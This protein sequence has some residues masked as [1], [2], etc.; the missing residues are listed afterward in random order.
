MAGDV[1]ELP[2]LRQE[3]DLVAGPSNFDGSPTWSLYDPANQRY[4]RIGQIE[5]EILMAWTQGT[6]AAVVEKIQQLDQ[7]SVTEEDVTELY[8]FLFSHNLLQMQG[9]EA[10]QHLLKQA[11][12][13]KQHW[14]SW[15]VHHYLFFKLPLLRPDRLL[16]QTYPYI[17]CLYQPVILYLLMAVLVINLYVLIDR[18]ELFSQTFLHFFSLEGMVFYG[19]ALSLAKI[20]HELGHAYTAHRYGCRVATMGVAFLVMFPVL[21]TDT[22]D[23]W[24]LTSRRQRLGIAIAGIAVELAL[25]IICTSLWHFLPDGA[26]RSAVFLMASTTWIMTLL[27]NL[28]PFMRFDGYYLLSDFLGVENLQ[29]RAFNLAKWQLRRALFAMQETLPEQLPTRLHR[30]LVAYAWG[31]WVYRFLLFLGIA[32]LVYHFFFKA[33]GVILMMIEII[34]FIALP[35]IKEIKH[36]LANREAISWNKNS[37]LTAIASVLLLLICFIPWQSRVEAPAVLK[38]AK[39]MDM[40]MPLPGQLRQVLV[41]RGDH[42][43]AGQTLIQFDSSDLDSRISQSQIQV[44][45]LRWQL[46]FYGQDKRLINRRRIVL[47]ELDSALSE[48]K[49]LLNEREKLLFKAPFEGVILDIND[50]LNVGEWIAQDEAILTLAQ[51][52]AYKIEA[53][54]N[55]AHLGQVLSSQQAIFYPEQLDWPSIKCKIIRIDNA[56]S[57]QIAPE[58]ASIYSGSVP[59]KGYKRDDL[60]PETSVYRVWLQADTQ[61]VMINRAIRGNVM[62]DAP[63]ESYAG[64]LWKRVMAVL[65]RESGF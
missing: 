51:D 7:L 62:I 55:E 26:L 63:A 17:R 14:F 58:Y 9:A 57:N 54:V 10:T 50:Q 6:A 13:A 36:W 40:Y 11:N 30:I 2:P 35:V 65:I 21:Y 31:T 32:L 33:L 24:K 49:S 27:I 39:Y 45:L 29:Q 46:S 38:A 19:F 56:S 61:D 8:Q 42:V 22:S 4:Y 53:L 3:L 25:A 41:S 1:I 20:L 48:Y 16:K 37:L 64:F 23:A 12:A 60:V 59:V 34:W 47:S 28:N 44:E 5:C 18:W 43:S 52:N 15:L